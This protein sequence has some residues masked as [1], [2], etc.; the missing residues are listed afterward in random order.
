M[1]AAETKHWNARAGKP[2]GMT[3]DV[4]RK[5]QGAQQIVAVPGRMNQGLSSH[6]NGAYITIKRG[7]AAETWF[8]G[9]DTSTN[10][11]TFHYVGDGDGSI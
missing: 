8:L 7:L 2:I 9:F 1:D 6:L 11:P 10:Q 4:A 5:L 3:R